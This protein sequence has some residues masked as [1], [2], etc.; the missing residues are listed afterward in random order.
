MPRP[1]RHSTTPAGCRPV[2]ITFGELREMG[3]SGVVIWCAD[4]R[5]GHWVAV[6]AD[7]WPDHMRLS[8]IEERFVCSACG[9]RGADVRPDWSTEG[10]PAPWRLGDRAT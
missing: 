9:M 3:L 1:A 8:D 6:S 7:A 5:C 2:K 4:Y 10:R